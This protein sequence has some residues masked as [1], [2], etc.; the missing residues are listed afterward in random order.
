MP[1]RII[2]EGILT[3][4]RVDQLDPPAEVFY[5]RLLSKVDDY[6]RYDAR[7]SVLRASLFPLRIDRVREADCS[8]WIAA[9]EKAGL[10]VLYVHDGKPYLEVANTGWTARSASK[11]PDPR[12]LENNCT[13]LKTSARLDVDVGV[14]V[15]DE[16]Q[17]APPTVPPA[18]EPETKSRSGT[19]L[20]DDWTLPDDWAEW[21]R[22]KRPDL[23]IPEQGEKFADFW[24]ATPGARG[25]KTD[26]L[27][28]WR[29]W[30]RNERQGQH[31]VAPSAV[32]SGK[33]KGP[34]ETPLERAVAYAKQ[35]HHYGAIDE[36]E[37][38]RLIAEA[39]AKHREAA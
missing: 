9:C 17:D 4:D 2:R 35:Q 8:R 29:N 24:R 31:T 18:A 20:P 30:I 28:T 13:Q 23:N 7:L 34:S 5:R 37:R 38:D 3:S 16:E 39:T 27:A 22:A 15:I 25:R 1:N 21:A 33:P 10:I 19:R 26:W 11:F 32:Q 12:T 14:V 36:A 6:G